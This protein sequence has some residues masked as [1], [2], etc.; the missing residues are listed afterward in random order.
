MI[1]KD[2]RNAN[3]HS[4]R[5]DRRPT[6][7]EVFARV[8][9]ATKNVPDWMFEGGSREL[10]AATKANVVEEDDFC[11]DCGRNMTEGELHTADCEIALEQDLADGTYH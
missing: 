4:D 7:E 9:E 2:A 8:C 1:V 11:E 6:Q 3:V 10:P 5:T